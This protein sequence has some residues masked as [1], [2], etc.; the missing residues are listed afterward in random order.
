MGVADWIQTIGIL[1]AFCG[2]FIAIYFSRKQMKTLNNH[3]KLDFFADYTKRYQEIMLNLPDDISQP[4]F[5]FKNLKKKERAKIYRYMRAYFDLCSEEYEL[6]LSNYIDENIWQNWEQGIKS[7]LAKKAFIQAWG[8][9]SF[10]SYY[11]PDFTR[12]INNILSKKHK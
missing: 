5:N 11:Y 9:V 8:H 6:H 10:N 12:W 1:V 3:L 7:N 4:D 2:I